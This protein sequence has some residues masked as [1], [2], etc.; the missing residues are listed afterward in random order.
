MPIIASEEGSGTDEGGPEM[1]VASLYNGVSELFAVPV[2]VYVENSKPERMLAFEYP[3][4]V[5]VSEVELGYQTLNAGLRTG[6]PVLG[7]VPN[8]LKALLEIELSIPTKPASGEAPVFTSPKTMLP[9]PSGS[10]PEVTNGP[11]DVSTFKV[12]L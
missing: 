6:A 2:A 10:P 7:S 9:H 4:H 8:P 5:R 1:R 3:L 12:K 11:V